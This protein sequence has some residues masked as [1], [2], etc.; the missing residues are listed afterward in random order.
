MRPCTVALWVSSVMISGCSRRMYLLPVSSPP[1]L[2]PRRVLL[3]LY[4]LATSYSIP[5]PVP[6]YI[7]PA[8]LPPVGA[9]ADPRAHR[10]TSERHQALRVPRTT[11][12]CSRFRSRGL[13]AH[14]NSRSW[15]LDRAQRRSL[16]PVEWRCCQ[17]KRDH[18]R[19][20][21][22]GMAARHRARLRARARAARTHQTQARAA[23]T[24]VSDG[25]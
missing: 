18:P 21:Q 11:T 25:P 8:Y 7:E 5:Y 17:R 14:S 2:F 22:E 24:S 16:A 12:S 3:C 20:A 4:Q 19:S 15:R 9:A 13:E 10:P 6:C 1:S 23:H